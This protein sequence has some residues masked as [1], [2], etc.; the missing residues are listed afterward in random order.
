MEARILAAVVVAYYLAHIAL[1]GSYPY[2]PETCRSCVPVNCGSP[3]NPWDLFAGRAFG[4]S[5]STRG[6]YPWHTTPTRVRASCSDWSETDSMGTTNGTSPTSPAAASPRVFGTEASN[7]T[8]E[9]SMVDKKSKCQIQR[10]EA[11]TAPLTASQ[12]SRHH[13]PTVEMDRTDD[14][15]YES[16]TRVVRSVMV[17]SQGVTEAR[18]DDYL[19]YVKNVGIELRN[20]LASVD[21]LMTFFPLWSKKEVEMAHRVLSKDMA[22]LVQAMKL[23]VKYSK[24]TLDAEYRKGMLGSAHA[25]ALD[26]KNLLDVVDSVRLRIQVPTSPTSPL[27]SATSRNGQ[28]ASLSP[29]LDGDEVVCSAPSPL[30][31][32]GNDLEPNYDVA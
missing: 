29:S 26:A 12:P 20:L 17:L 30:V 27:A 23:A 13:P 19:D 16:T 28:A 9:Y 11:A 5:N 25:L 21:E 31:T 15:V 7:G 18:V 22:N 10:S 4:G 24:T 6:R 14:R 32:A 2:K 8:L 3:R 1:A